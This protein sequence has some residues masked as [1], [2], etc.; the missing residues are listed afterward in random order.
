VRLTPAFAKIAEKNPAIGRDLSAASRIGAYT[1]YR[2]E[3]PLA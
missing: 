2:P 1:P 3:R